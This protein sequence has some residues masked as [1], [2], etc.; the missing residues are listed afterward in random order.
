MRH[1]SR[2]FLMTDNSPFMDSCDM[3]I[4]NFLKSFAWS[5]APV[6]IRF[7]RVPSLG[8]RKSFLSDWFGFA[9]QTFPNIASLG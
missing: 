4:P 7:K 6:L 1:I 3:R 5:Q 8:E 2:H 9:S